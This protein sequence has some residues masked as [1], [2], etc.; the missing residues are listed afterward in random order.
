MYKAVV[1]V[2]NLSGSPVQE[3]GVGDVGVMVR[4]DNGFDSIDFLYMGKNVPKIGDLLNV[5]I[6]PANSEQQLGLY[7]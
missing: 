1:R 2:C 6:E 5:T 7:A 3:Y 4:A